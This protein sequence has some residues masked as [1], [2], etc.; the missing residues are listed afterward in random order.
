ML[1]TL[2]LRGALL[3]ALASL[4]LTAPALGQETFAG[5]PLSLV[6]RLVDPAPIDDPTPYQGTDVNLSRLRGSIVKA[7]VKVDKVEL[8]EAKEQSAVAAAE[9]TPRIGGQSRA[10]DEYFYLS[11]E[12]SWKVVAHGRPPLPPWGLDQRWLGY[13]TEEELRTFF[14]GRGASAEQISELLELRNTCSGNSRRSQIR[15]GRQCCETAC[16]VEKPVPGSADRFQHRFMVV[17][18]AMGEIPLAQVKPD[19]L[20]WVQGRRRWRQR[21]EGDGV[22]HVQGPLVMPAGLIQ[23]EDRVHTGLK[24]VSKVIQKDRHR[25]GIHPRQRQREG[26]VR[27]RTAGREQVQAL[28][29]LINHARRTHAAFVPDP[30][31]PA[32]LA[33]ARFV[34]APELKTRLRMLRHD[35]LQL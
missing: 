9:F 16:L 11:A 20:H 32:L 18:H 7:L 22:W 12:P 30:C 21:Q 33:K 17:E 34:L 15:V 2:N 13:Q 25:I 4:L 14:S 29:A 24:L 27:A 1:S 19:P 26:L 35:G 8:I 3:G 6:R 23:H 5:D 10:W 31:R 28:E